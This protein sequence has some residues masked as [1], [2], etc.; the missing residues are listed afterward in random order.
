M[1]RYGFPVSHDL[2]VYMES[3]TKKYDFL[4][5]N[6]S[7]ATDFAPNGT[8]KGIG[9]TMTR[10][11]YADVLENIAKNGADA[12]YTGNVAIATV[13]A[14][15]AANGSMTLEDLQ[16]YRIVLRNPVE[17]EYRGFRILSCGA[18]ASGAV[19]LSALKTAE[20]YSG[21]GSPEMLN[22][23]THRLDEAVRFAYG[24]V[25]NPKL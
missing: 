6:P 20:G 19:V 15:Q 21:F 1:A 8:R 17:M 22:L 5:H 10:R 18:P 23:S 4:T 11:R 24:E 12:F 14:V 2:V 25:M 7:F 9:D 13:N 3:A 16:S